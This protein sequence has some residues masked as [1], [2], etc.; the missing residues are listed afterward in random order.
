MIRSQRDISDAKHPVGALTQT[1]KMVMRYNESRDWAAS[2]QRTLM[3]AGVVL[4][5]IVG[6]LFYYKSLRAQNNELANTYLTR[7]SDFYA[8]GDY[9]HAIDGDKT[10]RVQGEVIHGLK[11]IVDDYGSTAAGANAALLLANAYYYL[12][13]YD[14]A[15]AA[16]G[17]ATTATPIMAAS[18]DAGHAAILEA[19]GNKEEAAKLFQTA[20]KRDKDNPMNADYTLDAARDLQQIGKNDDAIKLYKDML[21]NFPG[22]EFDDAAKR[23]LVKLGVDI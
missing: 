8:A 11:Q 5:A 1:D 2:N 3:I 19:K 22:T 14:S 7:V 12:G 10:K 16:F 15:D 21:V 17:K 9:R 6:G 18:V 23:A 13:K 4:L 20:A